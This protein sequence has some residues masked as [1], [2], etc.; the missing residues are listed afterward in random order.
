MH[1][2]SD[3]F[4]LQKRGSTADEYED[5]ASP[6]EP[7]DAELR[8]FRAA[9]ADGATEASFS[10]RWALNLA[11]AYHN[12]TLSSSHFRRRLPALAAQWDADL[13]KHSLPWY[14]LDKL[15]RGAFSSLLGITL[16]DA[17][18]GENGEWTALAVGDS[19]CFQTRGDFLLAAFPIA[20][21]KQFD[22]HPALI[23]TDAAAN[24]VL[25]SAAKR[26][27][28][29]W[30]VGDR[31]LVMTDALALWFMTS[32]EEGDRPWTILHEFHTDQK[33]E[34][35]TWVSEEREGNRMHNDDTTLIRIDLV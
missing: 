18:D 3:T 10:G 15:A 1:V 2:I 21:A 30:R 31:F 13:P 16:S 22:N 6:A 33:E 27:K 5:A 20:S 4:W 25:S 32:V 35:S 7:V 28:G 9:T 11:A 8:V 26:H 17:G 14:A 29:T 12:G 23:S 24:A 34:F 19:C